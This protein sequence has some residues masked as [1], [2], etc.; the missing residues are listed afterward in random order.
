MCSLPPSL[1]LSLCLAL[2]V[3]PYLSLSHTQQILAPPHG[4]H[5]QRTRAKGSD[6][7][8]ATARGTLPVSLASPTL[9]IALSNLYS[10]PP[11]SPS[12]S[13]HAPQPQD[14]VAQHLAAPAAQ[15]PST[16][17]DGRTG[18]Q[19]RRIGRRRRRLHNH[20]PPELAVS[21][22]HVHYEPTNFDH[23]FA[24]R[25]TVP[26]S[27]PADGRLPAGSSADADQVPPDDLHLQPDGTE[28][29]SSLQCRWLRWQELLHLDTGSPGQP[30]QPD[31]WR[32]RSGWW[33]WRWRWRW[34]QLSSVSAA[35]LVLG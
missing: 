5:L 11:D 9:S 17:P 27:V 10:L 31:R 25:C 35:I 23:I 26:Q 14:N 12:P 32:S 19:W 8:V 6:T 28:R 13:Q 24:H 18:P 1:S 22:D 30:E 2:I 3:I 20:R 33:R 34:W 4:A 16:Q 7:T 15:S 21:A 29:T